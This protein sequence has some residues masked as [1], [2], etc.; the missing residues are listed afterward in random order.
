MTVESTGT[1]YVYSTASNEYESNRRR[2][3][4]KPGHGH[5]RSRERRLDDMVEVSFNDDLTG[6]AYQSGLAA[7]SSTAPTLS[8]GASPASIATG[9]SSTLS[10]SSSNG[11]GLHRI[12]LPAVGRLRISLRLAER[13]HHVRHQLHRHGGST[14][15]S[16]S[17]IV[18]PPPTMSWTQSLP[19]TFNN[20]AIV[21]FGGTEIRVLLFMDG[22]LYAGIGDWEDPQLKIPRPRRAS[23]A[24]RFPKRAAG[25]RTKTSIRSCPAPARNTIRRSPLSGR[26]ISITTRA[27]T[28]LPRSTS[29]WPVS[30][31]L[32]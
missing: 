24:T 32:A 17:V 2:G 1:A 22:S 30:R 23:P 7:A 20:P 25:S 26:R 13:N 29:S 19:V 18:N 11:A 9:A 21:P 14:T 3:A 15:R 12:G 31:M 5:R 16:A 28:R 8:F 6:W 4:G 27:T 10:W